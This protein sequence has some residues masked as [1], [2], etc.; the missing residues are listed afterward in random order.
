MC[1]GVD[2]PE[3]T[4]NSHFG[5]ELGR[6]VCSCTIPITVLAEELPSASSAGSPDLVISAHSRCMKREPQ[7]M[8]HRHPLICHSPLQRHFGELQLH[9]KNECQ[10]CSCSRCRM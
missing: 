6:Q 5:T 7:E 4:F 1:L 9:R 8:P 2:M 3:Q 10:C